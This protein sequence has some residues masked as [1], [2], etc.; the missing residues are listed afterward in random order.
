MYAQTGAVQ[1]DAVDKRIIN[2]KNAVSIKRAPA[3]SIDNPKFAYRQ[4]V[5]SINYNNITRTLYMHASAVALLFSNT[6]YIITLPVN[7]N[8]VAGEIYF[9]TDNEEVVLTDNY[10]NKIFFPLPGNTTGFVSRVT[11][12]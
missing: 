3:F 5:D 9:T 6:Q 4:R 1:R 10:I 11:S 2:F 7:I 12:L 8:F